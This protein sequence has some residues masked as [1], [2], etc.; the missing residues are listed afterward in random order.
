MN[1]EEELDLHVSPQLREVPIHQ[2]Y[3]VLPG[4][5]PVLCRKCYVK[6]TDE[7][8]GWECPKCGLQH[9]WKEKIA[10]S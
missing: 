7:K 10:A 4:V 5:R 2:L 6:M 1:E 3:R 8:F 9:R